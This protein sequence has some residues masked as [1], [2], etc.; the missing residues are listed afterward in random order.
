MAI[1]YFYGFDTSSIGTFSVVIGGTVGSGTATVTAGT[2][3]ISNIPAANGGTNYS[4]WGTAVAAALNAAVP[5]TWSCNFDISTY[6]Y[7]ITCNTAFTLTWTG[8]GGT[9]LR[10]SLGYVSTATANATSAVATLRAYYLI[11]PAIAG[12]SD[13][14]DV[15]EPE[16]IAQEAVSD[17]GTAYSVSRDTDELWC[18]WSQT[19]E[20]KEATLTRSATASVPWTWQ[21]AWKHARAEHPIKVYDTVTTAS[22]V[23]RMR[24]EGASFAPARVAADYDGLWNLEFRCRDLGTV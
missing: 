19:M 7:T 4:S 18:D 22:T 8:D 23:Y 6:L 3:S 21:H 11:V 2:Y 10:R 20:S 9:N 12:R 14:S 13:F 17:G 24:A 15:Y 5:A 1:P 16:E